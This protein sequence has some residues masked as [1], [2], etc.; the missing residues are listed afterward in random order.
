MCFDSNVKQ[1]Q[2]MDL[3]DIMQLVLSPSIVVQTILNVLL[4]KSD[5]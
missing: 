2:L 5:F 4:F 3:K 1:T